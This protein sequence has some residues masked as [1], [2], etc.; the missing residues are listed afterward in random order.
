MQGIRSSSYVL[1]RWLRFHILIPLETTWLFVT[2]ICRNVVRTDYTCTSFCSDWMTAMVVIG[3]NYTFWVGQHKEIVSFE[4]LV[5]LELIRMGY[6]SSSRRGSFCS[7]QS[8]NM[9]A[10]DHLSCW[11][12][13]WNLLLLRHY[14]N[15]G[16]SLQEWCFEI[17][18]QTHS[19]KKYDCFRFCWFIEFNGT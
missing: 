13:K 12:A 4:Q 18:L 16:K 1:H 3:N 14:V 8:N 2:K 15:T 9:D 17:L 6:V 19:D 7:D 5:H 10:R 11:L